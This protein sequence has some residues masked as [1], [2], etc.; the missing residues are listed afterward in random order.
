LSNA[1]EKYKG[2]AW[3]KR[4]NQRQTYVTLRDGK[5]KQKFVKHCYNS[6]DAAKE[7][8]RLCDE[9]KLPRQNFN[10]EGNRIL[11]KANVRKQNH[12]QGNQKEKKH[13][14]NSVKRKRGISE[15]NGVY[16]SNKNWTSCTYLPGSQRKIYRRFKT[17]LEAAHEVDRQC[18]IHNL[19][20]QNF[21]YKWKQNSKKDTI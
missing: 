12:D 14:I 9:H 16:P 8:D 20:R 6:L 15:Y 13:D 5:Q 19:P 3:D 11:T 7:V 2:V 21:G 1:V 4:T 17:P 10:L 18:D